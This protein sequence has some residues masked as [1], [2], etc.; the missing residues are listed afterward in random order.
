MLDF[1]RTGFYAL[2]FKIRNDATL[3]RFLIN[4]CLHAKQNVPLCLHGPSVSSKTCERV[5]SHRFR[6]G[7][8]TSYAAG[9]WVKYGY[10]QREVEMFISNFEKGQKLQDLW[11]HLTF[12]L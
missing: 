2:R 7:T 10:E 12:L 8:V 1:N 3:T 11:T 5:Q 6:R 4:A 9:L